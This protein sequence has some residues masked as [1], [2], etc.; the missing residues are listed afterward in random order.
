MLSDRIA[1]PQLF[2][3]FVLLLDMGLVLLNLSL[4]SL[5]FLLIRRLALLR[6]LPGYLSQFEWLLFNIK[7]HSGYRLRL[8]VGD[9]LLRRLATR[10]LFLELSL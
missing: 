8:E 6:F 5:D 2:E 7:R 3:L 9:S 1:R 10:S 4:E